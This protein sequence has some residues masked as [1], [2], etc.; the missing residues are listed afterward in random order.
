[1]G[2]TR[3][4]FNK[5]ILSKINSQSVIV[6]LCLF[7]VCL[8]TQQ[9]QTV[10]WN[11]GIIEF[12]RDSVGILMAVIIFTNYKRNDFVKYKTPYIIWS[13]IGTVSGIVLIPLAIRNRADYLKADTLIIFLGTFMMG[14]CVIHTVISFFIEKYRPKFY[15]PLFIM[16]IVMLILMITSRS[17]YL[18]PECYFVLFLC[19]YMTPQTPNQRSNVT[20]GLINGIILGYIAIQAHALLCRPYDRVRYY[21]NFCNPNHNSMFLCVCLAAILAKILF[22]TKENKNKAIKSFYFFLAGSCYSLICMTMCRSGYLAA[23]CAT[24]FFLIAY[25]RIKKKTIYIKMGGLLFSIFVTML[26]LTY[27][28]V[29]YIPTIH[30]HVLFY[31]QE[32]YSD[33]RVHSWDEW[34]SEKYVTFKQMLQ[35]VMERFGNIKDAL[36]T[37]QDA[38]NNDTFDDSL[39][40]ASYSAYIPME[41]S[42]S[43]SIEIA[44]TDND[45]NPKKVPALSEEESANSLVVRYTI[46]KWY[47]SHLSLR[48]MPYDEQGFQLTQNHWIQDTHNI[49][50]DYGI[51]FGYPVMVLF[52]IFIW[53]GIG[54]LTNQGLR[55]TDIRKLT[56][57]LIALIPPIF[58]L[59]EFAWGTGTISTV[60]LYLSFKEMFT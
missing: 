53:W 1:M 47:F 57:L 52:T 59:S 56:C 17:D 12:A 46:Y 11:T 15:L 36:E 44:D 30:P 13:V 2:D 35:G 28:A 8:G 40:V 21:G 42:A 3:M 58:G 55:T 43:A 23:L 14:Y 32:G 6:S 20:I 5:K 39:K 22:V 48:G 16:W 29:R 37:L 49:Y 25:C 24:V 10:A 27:L 51:N 7:A 41:I 4:Q 34:D 9:I 60:A 33:L 19:Y 54:R 26:P 50:L 38:G 45:F 18:W 31:F